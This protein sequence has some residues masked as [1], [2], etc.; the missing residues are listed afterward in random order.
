MRIALLI[1]RIQLLPP[2]PAR[3]PSFPELTPDAQK[4]GTNKK[5]TRAGRKW[6][7]QVSRYSQIT[8]AA[9]GFTVKRR[10][11]KIPSR[12]QSSVIQSECFQQI[13]Q[14]IFR[15]LKLFWGKPFKL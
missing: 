4:D 11:R 15:N 13:V 14:N 5:E 10:L 8:F 6:P 7:V 1:V 9:Y 12:T 2:S 3:Q